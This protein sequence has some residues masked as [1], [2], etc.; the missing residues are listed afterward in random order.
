MKISH[1][2]C[3]DTSVIFPHPKGYPLRLKLKILAE[4]HL[5]IKIQRNN[6]NYI[7]IVKKGDVEIVS[8]VENRIDNNIDNIDVDKGKVNI[9]IL[10]CM[11]I[12]MHM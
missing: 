1:S 11:N 12:C 4:K 9:Y 6:K 5:N 8:N 2:K 3:V 7:K 10:S